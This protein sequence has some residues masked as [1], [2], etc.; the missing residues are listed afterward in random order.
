VKLVLQLDPDLALPVD[1]VV[2]SLESIDAYCSTA[3]LEMGSQQLVMQQQ[4]C[5]LA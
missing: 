1:Q 3:P 2:K 5:A 4:Q